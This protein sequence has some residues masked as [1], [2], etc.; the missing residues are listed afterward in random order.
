MLRLGVF[1][2]VVERLLS[3]P[4]EFLFN[5][6]RQATLA[7][8]LEFC[9][10]PGA[11]LHRRQPEAQGRHQAFLFQRRRVQLKDQQSHIVHSAA[12]RVA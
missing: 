3:D 1:H 7:F 5:H 2:H 8:D 9:L 6:D 11:R 10:Q 12:R 4:I